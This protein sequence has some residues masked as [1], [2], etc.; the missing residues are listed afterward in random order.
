MKKLLSL[1]LAVLIPVFS[2]TACSGNPATAE[3]PPFEILEIGGYHYRSGAN[4]SDD[5]RLTYD[6]TA[7]EPVL[8]QKKNIICNGTEY[9]LPYYQ[10]KGSYLYHDVKDVYRMQTKE[11]LIEIALNRYTGRVDY[12]S[13]YDKNYLSSVDS[14][15]LSREECL[16]IARA[17]LGNYI[18]DSAQY[19][20]VAESYVPLPEFD[21]VYDFTFSR[22][23]DGTET[24]DR[25][26]IG[27]TVYGDVITHNFVGLGSMREAVLPPQETM[28]AI[29]AGLD[30]R[31]DEIYAPI[32]DK[33][34]VSYEMNKEEFIRLAD[35]S[36]ALDYSFDIH[37]APENSE[38][39]P[40]R[41]GTH[42]LVRLN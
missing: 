17:Y 30:E 18:E 31:L 7:K 15:E 3:L 13:W 23:F 29:Q 21:A 11:K 20:L 19:D 16:A 27:V 10:I 34:T 39:S 14:N 36:Y 9:E 35:G 5:I 22:L 1:L 38:Q 6:E 2:M 37:G 41:E 26:L 42:F 32:K 40:W 12:Y 28:H 4:H 24:C 33:Y 8:D 25:A